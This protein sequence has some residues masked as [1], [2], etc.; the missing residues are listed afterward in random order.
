MAY[1]TIRIDWLPDFQAQWGVF[2][3]ARREAGRLWSWLVQ[4]HAEFR[5]QGSPWPTTAEL[6]K[7]VKGLFPGLHSQSVQ[8]IVAD[9]CEAIASAE[10][11]RHKDQPFEYPHRTTTYRQ[12]IFTNQATKYREGRLILP[13]G[14]AGRLKIHIPK[15][16]V[17]PGRLMEVRLDY[18][19]VE[20]VC[21]VAEESRE[22]GPTIGIDLGVNTVIAATDGAKAILI[23]G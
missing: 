4:H 23:S 16:V 5:G 13:C 7:Q 21:Q 10:A 12:V 2:S 8:Q 11:L 17:L 14:Q 9:F 20:I 18:G 6:Q 22:A 1:R 3:A 19:W 15:G